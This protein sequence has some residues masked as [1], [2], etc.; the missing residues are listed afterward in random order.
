[1]NNNIKLSTLVIIVLLLFSNNL[2]E[3]YKIMNIEKNIENKE[4]NIV[5]SNEQNNHL[6]IMA[7]DNDFDT[8]WLSNEKENQTL[9]I[10]LLEPKI[11]NNVTQVF[12]D[13]DVW[14]FKIE[15]SYDKSNYFE[16]YDGTFGDFGRT[17][18]SSSSA[19]CRYIRLT[20]LKSMKGFNPSSKEFYV[21]YEDLSSGKNIALNQRGSASSY[22]GVYSPAKAFDGNYG[23]FY[24]ASNE[25]YPQNINVAFS[26]ISYVKNINLHFQ[27]Y[28]VYDFELKGILQNGS[29]V[30]LIKRSQLQG[31]SHKVEVEKELIGIFYQVYSG[32]G[33]ASLKEMEVKGFTNIINDITINDVVDFGSNCYIKKIISNQDIY[34]SID[35]INYEL[36]DNNSIDKVYRYLKGLSIEDIVYGYSINQSLSRGLS[37][38]VSS[39]LDEEHHIS[40]AT[41]NNSTS[42]FSSKN[43]GEEEFILLDLGRASNIQKVIQ[44][45]NTEDN[46]S[47]KLEASLDNEKFDLI[48]DNS[49]GV[50]GK[51]F[52]LNFNENAIYRY[53][54]LSVNCKEN[55]YL[56][57][58]KFDVI[59]NGSPV[60][61]NWWER[62]SGVIRFYPKEQRV[63]LRE[64]AD[65]LDEFRYGGY[66]VIELHQPYEGLADIWAG[67][68]GTNNYQVDPIIGTLD[69]LK[70]LLDEAHSRGMYIFMFGNVGYGKYNSDYF[71]K[72]C[73]DYALGI[74]SRERNWFLFSDICLDPTKWFW[75]D[76][77]GAYYYGYWGENGKIPTF[78]FENPE[79]QEETA[80][81]IDFWANFGVDG[82]ALDAPNVYY[83]GNSNA[84]QITY[85]TITNTMR[86][87][88]LFS[89][90]EGSGDTSFISSY[91]Y[92]GVQNYNMSSWG[93][94]AY[95]LGIDCVRKN[96]ATTIDDNI[97]PYRDTAVAV[98]GVSIAGMNFED[99]YLDATMKERELEAALVTSTGHL[100]FLHLGSSARIGQDIMKLWEKDTLLKI[101][102]S[103]SIQ[104]SINAL[105]PTGA[106]F[107]L[108]TSNDDKFY[109]FIKTDMSGKNKALPVF[110]YSNKYEEVQININNAVHKNGVIKLYDAY[111]DEQLYVE[112][113]NGIIKIPMNASSYRLLIMR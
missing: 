55:Q 88:N 86:K 60:R 29:E 95:S 21:D 92:S 33:W 108:N 35:G 18:S 40:K 39:Y 14:Y 43:K 96:K 82:I 28:G 70:Y 58:K 48:V 53:I 74:S 61:E 69:D 68:G 83:W 1:M 54:K 30:E 6:A 103:F 84:S 10:D 4:L 109:S 50:N 111:N 93:G 11:I 94:N 8:Y 44:E 37:G 77:A 110:N 97:K 45:F 87:N 63:T 5:S 113:T 26:S 85:Q 3:D 32:P 105:S 52:E 81:Y 107:K 16:L 51:I 56:T 24:C 65:R 49:H 17:F 46:Y 62:E 66:K 104:N 47:F 36:L 34:G 12:V 9:E 71:K 72:A 59:G 7:N 57:S 27:D 25:S 64:I 2:K 22:S 78:N 98:G 106:R 102:R 42:Y 73:K 19:V 76:T 38:I 67:L 20:I 91:Y 89:L 112:I 100:S 90:P 31:I 80:R 101:S 23:T 75:S 41:L 13:E 15:G 99:N 79:W